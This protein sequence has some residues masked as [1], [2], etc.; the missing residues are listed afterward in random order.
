MRRITGI[1][2]LQ[3]LPHRPCRCVSFADRI[4]GLDAPIAA[5]VAMH[6]TAVNC[7]AFAGNDASLTALLDNFLEQHSVNV[8]LA[9][10]AIAVLGEG[11][12]IRHGSPSSPNRQNRR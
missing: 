6:E 7:E 11:R 3:I 5:R 1:E 12:M 10:P 8:A 4:D 9:K 2:R